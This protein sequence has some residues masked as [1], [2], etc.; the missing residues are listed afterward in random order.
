[1]EDVDGEREFTVM[2]GR[3]QAGS[4]LSPGNIEFM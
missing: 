1:M 2:N 4:A 3:S